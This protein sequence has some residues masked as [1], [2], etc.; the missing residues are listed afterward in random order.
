M[1]NIMVL[2]WDATCTRLVLC[3][4]ISCVRAFALACFLVYVCDVNV[5]ECDLECVWLELTGPGS[6]RIKFYLIN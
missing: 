6:N 1:A 4:S 3:M 2:S 5:C